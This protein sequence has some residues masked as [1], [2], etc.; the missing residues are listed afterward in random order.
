MT[1]LQATTAPT[2]ARRRSPWRWKSLLAAVVV[3]AGVPLAYMWYRSW[4]AERELRALLA[5]LDRDDPGWR[6]EE[7]RARR[8]PVP[9]EQSAAHQARNVLKAAK[10]S[11]QS[12]PVFGLI[13]Q[14]ERSAKNVQLNQ[15]QLAEL[16]RFFAEEAAARAEAFKLKDIPFGSFD[17]DKDANRDWFA[18]AREVR[19][20]LFLDAVLLAQDGDGDA[21]L[22][23]CRAKL[24]V[25]H[26]YGVEPGEQ[27]LQWCKQFHPNA[28]HLIER[29]LA[30]TEPSEDALKQMQ[31]A[32]TWE[33]T[34]ELRQALRGNRARSWD[35]I[36]KILAGELDGRWIGDPASWRGKLSHVVP[37][38]TNG[39]AVDY[40][41]GMKRLLKAVE[42]PLDG[43][44]DELNRLTKEWEDSDPL[45]LRAVQRNQQ[46]I[47]EHYW[48]QTFLRMAMVAVAAERHRLKSG[49]WPAA[50]GDL[51][52]AG[53]L[54]RVPLD[55]FDGQPLR[56]DRH[57]DGVS[58]R[59]ARYGSLRL[60]DPAARRQPP[61][62]MP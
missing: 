36:E 42:P 5:D 22:A 10:G 6:L 25:A 29:V 7:L 2:L 45:F 4:A 37:L 32:L 41:R 46:S 61:A 44:F 50:L 33:T 60:W 62:R 39:D 21:A 56:W 48:S 24:N 52:A 35:E 38:A 17:E 13:T 11:L 19:L 28:I 3:L 8:K 57:A 26:A 14:I 59:S 9:D 15:E 53:V 16:R 1:P 20:W 54:D 27:G 18:A 49:I 30:Q 58:V 51:V 55:P 23:A 40:L 47:W 43:R 34:L 31:A 12:S